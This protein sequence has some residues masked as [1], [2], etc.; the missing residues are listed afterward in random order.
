[1]YTDID[2]EDIVFKLVKGSALADAVSGGVHKVPRPKNS[3]S[4]DIVIKVI[5]NELDAL[6]RAEVTVNVYVADTKDETGQPVMARKRL[7]T[8]CPIAAAALEWH[9]TGRYIVKLIKQRVFAVEATAE[10]VINNRL[11]LRLVNTNI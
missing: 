2:I 1:M 6:Q 5:A 8:L 10:H 9:N 7:R 3:K 11:E 4:E